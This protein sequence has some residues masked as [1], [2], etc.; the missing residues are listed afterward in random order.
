MKFQPPCIECSKR[1]GVRIYHIARQSQKKESSEEVDPGMLRELEE[2]IDGAKPGISPAQL[3]QYAIRIAQ[4]YSQCDDPFVEFKKANNQLAWELY[5]SLKRRVD[6]S[7]VPLHVASQL[8]ACGNI[9]DLGI[10]D[11]FDILATIDKVLGEGF[12]KDDYEEFRENLD[13]VQESSGCPQVLYVCDNAGEIVF[14]RILIEEMLRRY[15]GAE[16]KAMVR[17][18]P[19]LNDATLEDAKEVG[20]DQV[21]QV[22]DN[23]NDCLGT[24]LEKL[25]PE[26]REFY[27][28]ADVIISKGQANYETISHEDA[29]VFFILKAK[30][31][32]IASSLGVDMWDAVFTRVARP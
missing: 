10:H 18:A 24:V 30:C 22:V 2:T 25:R 21:C 5:S 15:P 32:V 6:G 17:Q 12:R 8:A 14:D 31:E 7:E 28:K 1:Q 19:V 26:V 3:S 29:R 23:G 13:H 4:K 20:L 16:I 9:I 27:E 11:E